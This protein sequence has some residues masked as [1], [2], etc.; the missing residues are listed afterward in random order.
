LL[1]KVV[2]EL[3]EEIKD[4][5]TELGVATVCQPYCCPFEYEVQYLHKLIWLVQHQPS[6]LVNAL[7][8][9]LEVLR[10][11]LLGEDLPE[12]EMCLIFEFLDLVLLEVLNVELGLAIPLSPLVLL[13][14][15]DCDHLRFL[16]RL[17]IRNSLCKWGLQ[18]G[19]SLLLC[20]R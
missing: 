11:Q 14:K 18:A 15:V 5:Y 1:L 17:E 7:A 12:C 10:K 20:S 3:S 19:T 8:V 13:T 2:E 16:L 9:Q 4:L 6:E